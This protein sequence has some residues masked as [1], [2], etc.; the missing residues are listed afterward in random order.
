MRPSMILMFWRTLNAIGETPRTVTLTSVPS[1]R[2]GSAATT[3]IS[4]DAIGVPCSSRLTRESTMMML[5]LSREKPELSSDPEPRCVTMALSS[6][7][8]GL[9]RLAEAVG[10]GRQ[11]DQHGDDQRDPAEGEQ[12]DLPA[13]EDVAD[14]VRNGKR[15]QTCLSIEVMFAR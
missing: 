13:D 6:G 1:P 4:G 3:F 15:H 12:R 10:H 14:V 7:A 8:G 11:R 2:L 5:A 9:Q